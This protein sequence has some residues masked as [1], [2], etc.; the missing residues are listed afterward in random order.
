M[1]NQI[2]EKYPLVLEMVNRGSSVKKAIPEVGMPRSSFYKYRYM[3]EMK[4]V[5]LAHYLYL[6]DQFRYV[7][8]LSNEC[9]EALSEDG[10]FGR[11]A[12][13]MRL[14]KQLLPLN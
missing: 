3:A 2:M 5:D 4:I 6:K 14:N 13:Q 11:Q 1:E 9:K 7:Q 10:D 8:Q 12:E